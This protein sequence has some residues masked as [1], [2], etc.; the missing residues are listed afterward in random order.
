MRRLSDEPG[1]KLADRRVV[2]LRCLAQRVKCF[3][4]PASVLRHQDALGL[5][6]GRQSLPQLIPGG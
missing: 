4:W 2:A 1:G 3:V 6:N 5:L